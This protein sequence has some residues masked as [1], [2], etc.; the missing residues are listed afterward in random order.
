MPLVL[1]PLLPIATQE[2][3]E[4][5]NT[6]K[7]LVVPLLAD[8]D[9]FVID[10]WRLQRYAVNGEPFLPFGSLSA[11][12][13][14]LGYSALVLYGPPLKKYLIAALLALKMTLH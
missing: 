7:L 10:V 5:Q 6:F 3:N 11:V 14:Y 8:I 4:S 1:I 12:L 9:I 2:V 13:Q